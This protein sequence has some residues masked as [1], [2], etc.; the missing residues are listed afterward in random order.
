MPID[1]WCNRV[2]HPPS[3]VWLF[4]KI[5]DRLLVFI[6][7]LDDLLVTE[8]SNIVGFDDSYKDGEPVLDVGEIVKPVDVNTSDFYFITRPG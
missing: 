4:C 6:S 8:P 7:E 2:D 5:S 1:R 3:N